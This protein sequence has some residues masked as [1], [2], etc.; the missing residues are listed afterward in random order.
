MRAV[1]APEESRREAYHEAIRAKVC[2]V[3]LDQR[4]DGTCGL[5]RRTCAIER[6]LPRLADVLARVHST[7]ME[8]Y[9]DAVRAQICTACPE[10]DADGRCALRE[11][12]DC[13]LLAYL[14]LV[15]DAIDSV[16]EDER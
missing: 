12:A 5:T 14:P 16:N 8:D 4:D 7:R 6:H 11:H 2:G 10:P 9:E 3:C 1:A 15:L 13:A